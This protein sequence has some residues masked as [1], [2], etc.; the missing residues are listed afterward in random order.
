MVHSKDAP[1]LSLGRRVFS[2]ALACLLLNAVTHATA[3]LSSSSLTGT[4]TDST[5]AVVPS[6][7]VS[8]TSKEPGSHVPP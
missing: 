4:V 6:V 7:T 3:Q 5:G 8:A 2:V 1:M